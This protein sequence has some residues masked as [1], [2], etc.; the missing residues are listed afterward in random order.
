M[1]TIRSRPGLLVFILT[2]LPLLVTLLGMLAQ[3]GSGTFGELI[4][5]PA[6]ILNGAA[7]PW[8]AILGPLVTSSALLGVFAWLTVILPNSPLLRTRTMRL[9]RAVAALGAL[10]TA[11]T[12]WLGILLGDIIW[13]AALPDAETPTSLE[14]APSLVLLAVLVTAGALY[15]LVRPSGR[16]RRS[17]G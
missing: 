1:R 17:G 3:L 15:G 5:S 6:P 11:A 16:K 2:P 8:P 10:L 14:S 13:H 4:L 7:N 12:L 9:K